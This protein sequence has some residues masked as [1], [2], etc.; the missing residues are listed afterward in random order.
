MVA[1]PWHRPSEPI[2]AEGSRNH[3]AV[4]I[5]TTEGQP[6][7]LAGQLR[8]LLHGRR[9]AGGWDVCGAQVGEGAGGAPDWDMAAQPVPDYEVDQRVNW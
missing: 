4:H 8:T 9:K 7:G 1:N 5:A 3:A 6:H 2:P